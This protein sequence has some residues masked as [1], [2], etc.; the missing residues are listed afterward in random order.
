[1]LIKETGHY[2][3]KFLEEFIGCTNKYYDKTS[4]RLVNSS[5]L[6]DYLSKV[7]KIIQFE[8][9][10]TESI[11]EVS[12][13]Q[14]L[15]PALERQLILLHQQYLLESPHFSEVLLQGDT[16]S[17]KLLFDLCQPVS[18]NQDLKQ[19]WTKFIVR[20]CNQILLDYKP[21]NPY[22]T[23]E[24]LAELYGLTNKILMTSFY[25]DLQKYRSCLKEGFESSLNENKDKGNRIARVLAKFYD[26][27]LSREHNQAP[28]VLGVE[29]S[30]LIE[31]FRFV[32]AKDVFDHHYSKLL[33][34][35]L[36]SKNSSDDDVEQTVLLNLKKEC[37]NQ[38]THKCE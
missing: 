18:L 10:L 30:R 31:V 15:I 19:S 32:H 37:G 3:S 9:D 4:A 23:V 35:R 12:S 24:R 33:A 34:K 13:L 8:T 26:H 16:D 5:Q 1:M 21:E 38:F 7:Q 20:E 29:D 11:F 17:I 25:S 27:K 28:I 6:P 2:Q 22:S 36:L 14:E